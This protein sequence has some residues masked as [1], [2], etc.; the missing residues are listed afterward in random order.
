LCSWQKAI[1]DRN[2]PLTDQE[3]D[4]MLPSVGYE[5]IKPPEN[6]VPIRTPS[7]KLAE[8]PMAYQQTPQGFMIPEA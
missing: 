6:Y 7:R 2:R 4:Q 8:T 5:I 1:D 3:L